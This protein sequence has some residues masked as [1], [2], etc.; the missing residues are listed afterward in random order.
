MSKSYLV[1]NLVQSCFLSLILCMVPLHIQG[2]LLLR[3]SYTMDP[4]EPIQISGL[5]IAI[6][7]EWSF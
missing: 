3:Y 5:L 6:E 2:S 7:F 4:Q 1:F